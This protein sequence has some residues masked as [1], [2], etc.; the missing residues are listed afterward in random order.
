MIFN[1]IVKSG[2]AIVDYDT[3]TDYGMYI[4]AAQDLEG[5][6]TVENIIAN[7]KVYKKGD[8]NV[9]I[10][11]KDGK[12]VIEV[13]YDEELYTYEMGKEFYAVFFVKDKNN[14]ISCG[15]VKT[16]SVENVLK[17]YTDSSSDYNESLITLCEKMQKMNEVTTAYRNKRPDRYEFNIAK[18]ERVSDHN[19]T[20]SSGFFQFDFA[21]TMQ[22][23][24]I[25]PWALVF[26]GIVRM[27]G[28]NLD[29]S[30]CTEYGA[31]IFDDVEGKYSATPTL[32]QL[33]SE[34]NA[35]VYNNINGGATVKNGYISIDFMEGIYSSQ[36]NKNHHAVFYVKLG[37]SY[38]YGDVKTR[39]MLSV[40]Q[41]YFDNAGDY[42]SDLVTLLDAMKELYN[43]TVGYKTYAKSN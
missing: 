12:N 36:M 3:L 13:I 29:Y 24:T 28:S 41:T 43:A 18:P 35:Y 42:D 33:L 19:F 25:E 40:A 26:N 31:I 20:T 38:Y 32:E 27:N 4:I 8:S 15:E 39:S 14:D 34:E 1:G 22:M 6:A 2:D 16:R 37:N 11:E 21:H 7:G 17:L 5:E 9:S 10:V 23:A 30:N